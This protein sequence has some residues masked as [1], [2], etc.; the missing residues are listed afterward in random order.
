MSFV[1]PIVSGTSVRTV[2]F[3]YP[4]ISLQIHGCLMAD[5]SSAWA[6]AAIATQLPP[7]PFESSKVNIQPLQPRGLAHW[8]RLNYHAAANASERSY[9]AF[10]PEQLL[11]YQLLYEWWTAQYQDPAF[12]LHAILE[13]SSTCPEAFICNLDEVEAQP[14]AEKAWKFVLDFLRLR[15]WPKGD[16]SGPHPEPQPRLGRHYHERMLLLFKCEFLFDSCYA[17]VNEPV[18][19]FEYRANVRRQAAVYAYTQRFAWETYLEH[20]STCVLECMAESEESRKL[21]LSLP[22]V[23]LRPFDHFLARGSVV[24][25]CPWLS[26]DIDELNNMP[27]YLWD[28]ENSC[29]VTTSTLG[30]RPDYVAISHT[31][32]RWVKDSPI[33]ITGV[34]DWRVPQNKLFDV[35]DLPRLLK[36]VPGGMQYAWM[37]LLCIPQDGS[38]IGTQEIARQAKI[39]QGAKYAVAWLNQVQSFEG[40]RSICQWQAL[41]QLVFQSKDDE[42]I[43]IACISKTWSAIAGKQSGLLQ[44]RVGQLCWENIGLD[45]W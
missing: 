11:S 43:R 42:E 14:E 3:L 2:H 25:P 1:A 32:G 22:G 8:Y 39:F 6:L 33:A 16:V 12:S 18:R 9:I 19:S 35:R 10:S 27:Y 44:A 29:T 38:I 21:A 28:I 13:Y 7:C 4:T 40:L 17:P 41:H 26:N 23:F 37:D 45:P 20:K 36:K 31:W 5:R 34:P 30:F 15:Q 24:N